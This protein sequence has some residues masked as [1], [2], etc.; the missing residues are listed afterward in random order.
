[1]AQNRAYSSRRLRRA[2]KSKKK[3][4]FKGGKIKGSS[5]H[6]NE[7]YLNWYNGQERG[8]MAKTVE[9]LIKETDEWFAGEFMW[10]EKK[11]YKRIDN[12]NRLK[13]HKV[14]AESNLRIFLN[15]LKK[16]KESK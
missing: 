7:D 11:D 14:I 15:D 12:S 5:T 4:S 6:T 1:M 3:G 16:I 10:L 9:E 8:T 13:E 2:I